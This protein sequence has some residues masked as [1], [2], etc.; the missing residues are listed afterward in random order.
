[1]CLVFV[2]CCGGLVWLHLSPSNNR[3]VLNNVGSYDPSP[4]DT[5]RQ[6][7][8]KVNSKKRAKYPKILILRVQFASIRSKSQFSYIFCNFDTVEIQKM[9]GKTKVF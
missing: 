8:I 2:S 6:D 7:L 4:S 9:Y 5:I 3:V 1:M